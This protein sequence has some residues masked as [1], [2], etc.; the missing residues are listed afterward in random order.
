[1][2]N[3]YNYMFFNTLFVYSWKKWNKNNGIKIRFKASEIGDKKFS[4][5]I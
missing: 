2:I 1:M 4:A 5:E 3:I